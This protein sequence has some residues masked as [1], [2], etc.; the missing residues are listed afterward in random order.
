MNSFPVLK[1]GAVAQ[2]PAGRTLS[3]ST[4]VLRFVDGSEQRFGDYAAPLH[5]WTIQVS[6]LDETE[7]HSLQEFFREMAGRAGDFAFTDPWDGTVYPSCSLAA[8]TMAE[9]FVAE[10][11]GTTVLTVRENRS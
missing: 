1:T 5:Q 8:D 11:N 3:Y 6:A 10:L 7:M 9:T 2:Y 4:Q